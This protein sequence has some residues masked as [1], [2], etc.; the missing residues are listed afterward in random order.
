MIPRILI[1]DDEQPARRRLATLLADLAPRCPHLLAGEA[2]NAEEAL[3]QI[4]ALQP[5]LVLLDVQMPG[6]DG[7][8]LARRLAREDGAPAIV[9]V[10][11]FEEHALPAFDVRAIDYLLKP[12]RA[13]RLEQA[14]QRAIEWRRGAA[15]PATDASTAHGAREHFSVQE[16][17][18]ILRVPVAEVLYL[19]AELKYVTLRTRERD[20]LIEESLVSL[21]TELAASFVRVHR[22]ALVARAAIA[23]VA[24][25]THAVD[26]DGERVQEAWE[27]LVKG[28]D[29]RLPIS[30]RQWPVIRGLVK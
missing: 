6:M 16:R 29:D 12:V 15:P 19:K 14:I 28:V 30:R 2:A 24:R 8:T 27:V 3:R 11:A 21:E 20:Y 9:F 7:L 13:A 25:G 4:A 5:D 22:N 18:R 26:G 23:G 10:T 17:G 1:V